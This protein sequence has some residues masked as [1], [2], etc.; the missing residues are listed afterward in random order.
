MP[1]VIWTAERVA[2]LTAR[3]PNEP[4]VTL[5]QEWGVSKAAIGLKARALGIHKTPEC[6]AA[7]NAGRPSVATQ[8]KAG[9]DYAGYWRRYSADL[10]SLIHLRGILIKQ[11]NRRE[12]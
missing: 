8:L 11:I 5:A 9:T 1:Q 4:N 7:C 12:K 6:I 10:A 2:E 3:Y